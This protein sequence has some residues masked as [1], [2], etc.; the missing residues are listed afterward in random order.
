MGLFDFGKVAQ[1]GLAVGNLEETQRR[2]DISETNS[3][4]EQGR[5]KVMQDRLAADQQQNMTAHFTQLMKLSDDPRVRAN[6]DLEDAVFSKIG[7]VSGFPQFQDKETLSRGR[8]SLRKTFKAMQSNDPQTA[9]DGLVELAISASPEDFKKFVDSTS[10]FQDMQQTMENVGLMREINQAQFEKLHDSQSRVN[11]GQIPYTDAAQSFSQALK[12]TDSKEFAQAMKF[13]D[14]FKAKGGPVNKN[15]AALYS[16]GGL[17]K[18]TGVEVSQ[19]GEMATGKASRYLDVANQSQQ[20]LDLLEHGGEIP[21][22]VTKADLRH[23]VTVGRQV[24]EAYT[25]LATWANDPFDAT[26]LKEAKAAF[27]TVEN[28]RKNMEKLNSTNQAEAISIRQNA[29]TFKESEAYQKHLQTQNKT[30]AQNEFLAWVGNYPGQATDKEAMREAARIGAAYNTPAEDVWNAIKNPNKPLVENKTTVINDMS[31]KELGKNMTDHIAKVIDKSYA[32]AT[33]AVETLDGV[34]RI[35][36]AMESGNI[37]LGPGATVRY[38]A[39]QVAQLMGVGGKNEEERLANTRNAMRALAQF[40]LKART[41]LRGEGQITEGEQA[42]LAKAESGEIE[43]FTQPDLKAFLTVTDRLAR[44]SYDNHQK[45][46][47]KAKKNKGSEHLAQFYEMDPLPPPGKTA[48]SKDRVETYGKRE[49]G[50]PKGAG[51]F[52]EIQSPV[53]PGEF[54]TELTI[55]VNLGGK[56]VNIPLLTPNLSRTE[57]ESVMRGRE[58][59]AIIGKA[60]EHAKSRMKQG[61]SPYAQDGEVGSLPDWKPKEFDSFYQSL[62]K[63]DTYTGPDG[64]KRTKN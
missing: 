17:Q 12:G 52:G 50:S 35:R 18:F 47:E 46:L 42:V 7:E 33:S 20:A 26:K 31:D 39:S 43:S 58:N 8:E 59:K 29:Q 19:I 41:T 64:K 6:P 56:D 9:K 53:R 4:T 24:S 3:V 30:Q 48:P 28:E 2:N 5:L 55:G 1:M 22:G 34:E 45:M 63:G 51:Y 38:A 32:Q 60:V 40:T 23:R 57:I 13:A 21:P 27:K 25:T 36:K 10:K 15:I 37:I 49:D 62:R 16:D 44:R 61:K 54:S 11:A 14:S